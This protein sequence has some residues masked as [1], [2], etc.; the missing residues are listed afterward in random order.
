[1]QKELYA[2]G[3][4]SPRK[5]HPWQK[6]FEAEFFYTETDQLLAIDDTK[7]DMESNKP[8]D[9]LICGDVGYGKTEVAIRAFT[10]Y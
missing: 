3:Y 2:E 8:I 7:R 9:R 4:A 6:L 1:M 5:D 10:S